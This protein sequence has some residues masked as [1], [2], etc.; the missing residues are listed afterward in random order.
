MLTPVPALR[1][2]RAYEAPRSEYPID[3]KLDGNEGPPPPAAMLRLLSEAPPEILRGYPRAAALEAALAEA[4]GLPAG[5]ALITAGGDEALDRLC[6]AYLAPGREVILP[7][8]A[9]EM[10]RHYALL[11]GATLVSPSWTEAGYPAAEARERIG[12]ATALVV[13]TSPNNPTG[14]VIDR[15]GLEGLLEAAAARDALLLLDA[16]YAEFADEDLTALA[17]SRPGGLVLRT[18]SKA[19]GLAGL[20]VG[21]LLGAPEVLAPLRAAGG[22]FPVSGLS[23][24]LVEQLLAS[25]AQRELRERFIAR[26]R[27]ERARLEEALRSLGA[28]PWPSQGNFVLARVRDAGGLR[29]ALARQGIAVR[30]FPGRASLE[31]AVRIALP[32]DE[33]AFERLLSSLSICQEVIA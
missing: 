26:V 29:E 24:W 31:D 10:S 8:P 1:A 27:E 17:L 25:P 20:R 4:W 9:F 2:L 33:A 32:G 13:V 14:G 28:R 23:L 22:P 5:G 16:A 11:A 7:E 19:W 3:L 15:A 18:F 12:E 30:A 21:C 6:R